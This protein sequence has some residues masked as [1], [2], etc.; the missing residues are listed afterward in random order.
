M[1]LTLW[2][3]HLR[4]PS[5]GLHVVRPNGR[6][7][8]LP[9]A[10]WAGAPTEVD[11]Q[12]LS[13]L[14]EPVLDVGCGP[15]RLT[16]AL[17]ARGVRVLGIDVSAAAVEQARRAGAPAYEC[18]VFGTVPGA[19]EWGCAVLADGNIGIGGD[20]GRLL[21]TVTR[22]LRPDGFVHVE[23]EPDDGYDGTP[24]VLS[25][26]LAGHP[27]GTAFRWARVSRDGIGS[28][29]PGTGLSLVSVWSGREPDGQLRSFAVL[30]R[31]QRIRRS[32]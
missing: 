26:R 7:D 10:R 19:G 27:P 15:G 5:R 25:L 24:E 28:V 2:E 17:H 18:S 13:G 20:P 16:A 21:A 22:L 29:L 3:A 30:Q 14:A 32:S 6:C 11:L 8:V 1:S 31:P 12:L 23:I 4:E 9:T